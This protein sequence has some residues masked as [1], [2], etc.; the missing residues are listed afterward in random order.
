MRVDLVVVCVAAVALSLPTLSTCDPLFVMSAPNLL[1]VG[2]PE[3]VFVEAQDYNNQGPLQVKIVVSKFPSKD[4]IVEKT[5]TLTKPGN[6]RKIEQIIIPPT[7]FVNAEKEFVYL[8]AFFPNHV[9]EKVILLSFQ[10]GYIFLQTDKTIYTP[11]STV[12]YRIFAL[13]PDLKPTETS[14]QVDIMNQDGILMSQESITLKDAKGMLSRSYLIPELVSFGTWSLVARFSNTPQKTFTAQFELKEYVLPSFE[15]ILTPRK[16]FYYVNDD[17]LEIDIKARYLYGKEVTGMAFVMF[18]VLIDGQKRSLPHSLQ[19]VK[20]TGGAGSATLR[21]EHITSVFPKVDD[22]V[23]SSIY[24]QVSVLTE[25]GSEMVEAEKRGIMIVKSPYTIN[26]KRTPTYFKPGMPFSVIVY[27]STPDASPA[28]GIKVAF[29]WNEMKEVVTTQNNGIAEHAIN[30]EANWQSLQITATTMDTDLAEDRQASRDMRVQPYQT[31]AGSKNYLHIKVAGHV[32][33]GDRITLNFNL[34]VNFKQPHEI[35]YLILSRGK[36]VETNGITR[37]GQTVLS[38]DLIV[39]KDMVP[40]FRI[41]AY[42]HVGSEVVSDSVWVDVE[43]TCMGKLKVEVIPKDTRYKPKGK[44]SLKITGDPGAK[45]GLV[46]VDKGVYV[47]NNKHRLTQSKVWDTVEKLN[48]ACTAGSG[49]DSMGVFYDAGLVF[50]T[51]AAGGTAVRQAPTC[52]TQAKRKRRAVTIMEV[53]TTAAKNYFG[54]ERQCCVD[55]MKKN[56]LGYS[57]ERRAEF[58]LDGPKCKVAFLKCCEIISKHRDEE[59]DD[60]LQLARSDLLEDDD[61]MDELI[62]DLTSRSN[63]PESWLWKDVTH[64]DKCSKENCEKTEIGYFPD[65]ITS[66]QLSAISLSDNGICVSDT[67]SMEINVDFF[68]DLK[69]PYSAVRHEQIEIR[70][71]IHNQLQESMN[72]RVEWYNTKGVCSV[73]SQSGKYRTT[74]HV[75]EMSTLAV[76]FVIV[77][78]GEPGK[79]IIEVKAIAMVHGQ[80]VTDGIKKDLLVVSEG[81]REKVSQTIVLDPNGGIQTNTIPAIDSKRKVLDSP[82]NTYITVQGDDLGV[83]IEKAISGEVMKN[84]IRQPSG[85]SEQNMAYTTMPVIAAHYL[86]KTKQWETVG[87][88]KRDT[89]INFIKKGYNNQVTNH[90]KPDGYYAVYTKTLPGT[91][92][93]AY[94]AKVFS[95]ASDIISV[96][97]NVICSA[98]KWLILNRQQPDGIFM[99][100]AV[101]RYID[102][103]DVFGTDSDAS[104]TAFVLIAM[105]EGSQICNSFQ[106][107]MDSAVRYLTG[108]IHALKNPY[109]AAMVSYAL[110]NAGKLDKSI[111]YKF[112]H[113]DGTHWPVTGNHLLTVEATAYALLALVKMREFER[114]APVVKWLN[115]QRGSMG[116][117]STTQPTIMVFQALAEYRIHAPE[118]PGKDLQVEIS[119]SGRSGSVTWTWGKGNAFQTR[120]DKFGLDEELTITTKGKGKGTVF[121]EHIYYATP[122][123]KNLECEQFSLNVTL[124]KKAKVEAQDSYQAKE[125]YQLTIDVQFLG[126]KDSTNMPILDV[127]IPT[128][129]EV[130]NADLFKLQEGKDRYIQNWEKDKKLSE[131][132]SIIIYLPKISHQQPDRIAFKLHKVLDVGMIQPAAVTVYQYYKPDN[133]CVKFYPAETAE[134]KRLCIEDVCQCAEGMCCK[135][136]KTFEELKD[137]AKRACGTE[138]D[139]IFK[140]T[141][142]EIQPSS[143]TDVFN[144]KVDSMLKSGTD[145]GMI[146]GTERLFIAHTT[147]RDKMDLQVTKSYLIM[148]AK[149]DVHKVKDGYQFVFGDKTWI[150]YWPTETEGQE[151][152]FSEQFQQL[153]VLAFELMN[154]GCSF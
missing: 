68:M 23:H 122:K 8:Q 21:K 52:Q 14:V 56:I 2:S 59:R 72:V 134:L 128:G 33:L 6:F 117:Y 78:I 53:Q 61:L 91:W 119:A 101:L 105:Q 47:L 4:V 29:E 69:L 136:K 87:V 137:R 106:R 94:V 82:A 150:E 151:P 40:S 55:G 141:V 154:F 13:T 60:I 90:R 36:L 130:D 26:Y 27:V 89:A 109:A 67:L 98:L 121:V 28:G 107:S 111:L 103:G 131:R 113:D 75:D 112:S 50:E 39:T 108:K 62:Q 144:I 116:G 32:G 10:S 145:G 64:A 115:E 100:R 142:Q 38:K 153:Q 139:Y 9:L 7:D 65:S 42:Y 58:I 110:A 15:I 125:T 45:V 66:W 54:E 80:Y 102:S 57:C 146:N 135:Q 43:N 104:M 37:Q 46:A 88:D 77:P 79:Y 30:T 133:S 83:T 74:V 71:I 147:C 19:R 127:S 95:M 114:A 148:G 16:T 149:Q 5:V 51:N 1:R 35:T 3:Y 31:K 123:Q 18:G 41:V 63:F 25:T 152:E 81:V 49:K 126:N 76:P 96:D 44:L 143:A 73:A 20:V 22:I 70:A 24:V 124:M 34:Q 97:N 17:N 99:E 120:S 129:F 138:I 85:C 11:S 118:A 140:G 48:T 84:L 93:T 86:D 12:Y 92:L 132:G